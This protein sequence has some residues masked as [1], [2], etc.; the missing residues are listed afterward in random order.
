MGVRWDRGYIWA[1]GWVAGNVMDRT[2]V[3]AS[4]DTQWQQSAET[5]LDPTSPVLVLELG[6]QECMRFE[7][8]NMSGQ[9]CTAENC[10]NWNSNSS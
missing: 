8:R 5:F 3:L 10:D 1:A 9:P 2:V 7:A 6:T 4:G